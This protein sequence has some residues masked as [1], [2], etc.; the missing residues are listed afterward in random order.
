MARTV[1]SAGA[2][3]R[4]ALPHAAA[5]SVPEQV[6]AHRARRATVPRESIAIGIT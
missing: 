5:E 2:G 3:R 6:A 4:R 1:T